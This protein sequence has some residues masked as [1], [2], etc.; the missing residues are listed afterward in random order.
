MD[1]DDVIDMPDKDEEAKDDMRMFINS[2]KRNTVTEKNEEIE[3]IKKYMK[4]K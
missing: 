4:I 3:K 2:I 1:D